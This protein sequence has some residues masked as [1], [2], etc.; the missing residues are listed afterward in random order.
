[1]QLPLP[2][3]ASACY[4]EPMPLLSVSS[5]FGWLVLH[6]RD[7]AIVALRWGDSAPS[8]ETPLLCA[9]RDQLAAYFAG[10]SRRFTLPLAPAGTVFQR[11][12]WKALTEIGFGETRTYGALAQSLGSGPRAVGGACGRNPIPLL[13]PCHRV[14][15]SGGQLGGYSGQGGLVTKAALLRLEQPGLPPR[16][17]LGGA[18]PNPPLF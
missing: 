4:P 5:P 15:G 18:P 3:L 16:S 9:A 1:V 6:E 17:P 14:I 2:S 12:V 7:G 11:R 13:I 8:E 10:Q